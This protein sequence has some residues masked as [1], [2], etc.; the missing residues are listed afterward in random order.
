MINYCEEL[1]RIFVS[2]TFCAIHQKQK[3]KF[4]RRVLPQRRHRSPQRRRWGPQDEQREVDILITENSERDDSC[5]WVNPQNSFKKPSSYLSSTISFTTFN[6]FYAA[7]T[8]TTELTTEVTSTEPQ[9][10]EYITFNP[11]FNDVGDSYN[12]PHL[13]VAYSTSRAIVRAHF[14]AWM[15]MLLPFSKFLLIFRW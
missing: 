8:T 4:P 11:E 3:S 15:L 5:A 10:F 13:N 6:V 9:S 7:T 12:R 2:L 14:S 1:F